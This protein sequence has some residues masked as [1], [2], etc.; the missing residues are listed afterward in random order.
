LITLA[1]QWTLAIGP[2]F[3]PPDFGKL[4]SESDHLK[5]I[6]GTPENWLWN[7]QA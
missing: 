7:T 4:L 6:R 2:V 5:G 3:A 1:V